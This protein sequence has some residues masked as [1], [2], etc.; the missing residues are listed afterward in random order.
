[1]PPA[2][3]PEVVVAYAQC[4]R[5]AYLLLFGPEQGE[6]HEYIRI[7]KGN[8]TRI[9]RY[10]DRLR[11]K[12]TDVQPYTVDKLGKGARCYRPVFRLTTL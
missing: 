11:Q 10:L 5:K 2:I 8:N 7:L 4:P 9:K 6:P 1:M 3:T 12:H